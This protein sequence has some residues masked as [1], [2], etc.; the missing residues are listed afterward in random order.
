MTDK[1]VR[2]H[3]IDGQ[4]RDAVL[5]DTFPSINPATGQPLYYA[6]RGTA[7]DIDLAVQAAR[8]AFE[9]PAWSSLSATK[10][11][12]LLRRL[13]DLVGE[14]AELL[15]RAESQDNGK[16]LREM[17]GQLATLPEW[18]YYFAGIAD[19]VQGDVIPALNPAILN[20]TLAEPVGVVGAIS[21]W[22]SPL[23]LTTMKLA[24]ALAAGNTIVIKPSEHTSASL[25]E[26][27]P[28]VEQA[29]I[30]N[31][32]VNVVTGY[33]A[34]AGDA[35]TRHPGV[36]K[37]AFTGGTETGRRI[38]A[39]AGERLVP[40]TLELGGKSP[41]IVFPDANLHNAATGIIAGIYAAA[42]QTCV[43]GSRVLVHRDVHDEILERVANRARTIV[44][45][46]PLDESTEIGPL[47]FEAHR[48]RVESFVAGA[49]AQGATLEVGGARP[50][51]PAGNPLPGWFYQPTLFSGVRND[52]TIAQDEIFGPVAGIIPFDDDEEA[53][54]IAN[55]S[56]FGLAAGVWT[57]NVGRAHRVAARLVAGTVWINTYRAL[58]PMSPLGGFKSSGLGKENGF[59]VMEQ[60]TRTKSVWVNTDDSPAADPFVMR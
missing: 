57:S 58:S 3:Y 14:N 36:D 6:A 39:V 41:N 32:V 29:G 38:A 23:L 43:G 46:D 8:K 56:T 27:M 37:I 12:H 35:L 26:L 55:D 25:L 18:F 48:D 16:L 50:N 49:I 9:S 1:I 30:P 42:G 21:P 2:Q 59:A 11:G 54:R 22:N 10:R 5:G 40:V 44:V 53:V 20:Y 28:L 34:D 24:P 19:K 31:G 4:W 17:R 51:D 33:G 13:G 7:E 15:A 47:A 45:G 60:Y 52:M